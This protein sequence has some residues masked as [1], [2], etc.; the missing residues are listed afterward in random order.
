MMKYTG[1][2][3]LFLGVFM[4]ISIIFP[5]LITDD[6][7]NELAI[8]WEIEDARIFNDKFINFTMIISLFIT[9]ALAVLLH[10]ISK[11]YNSRVGRL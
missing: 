1:Y 7:R 3:L 10:I 2:S 5:V 8:F 11:Y 4:L 6:F 9:L